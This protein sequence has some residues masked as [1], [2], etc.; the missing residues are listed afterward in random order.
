M[1]ER[2]NIKDLTLEEPEKQPELS[3]DPERDIT[4]KDFED[5]EGT[6]RVYQL[7]GNWPEALASTAALKLISSE[8]TSELHWDEKT[9]QKIKDE[10][11]AKINYHLK[12]G[13]FLHVF[14][15][16]M[17]IQTLF[18][19]RVSDFGPDKR[20]WEDTKQLFDSQ[21]SRH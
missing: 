1:S 16:A 18:P 7:R 2:I 17:E 13:D 8:R 5:M 11:K 15:L 10:V 6:L 20:V 14:H 19:H 4:E 9:R 12:R 3:F 21:R